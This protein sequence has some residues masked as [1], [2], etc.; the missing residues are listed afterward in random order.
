MLA[1]QDIAFQTVEMFCCDFSL[2]QGL[3]TLNSKHW[4]S[5][6]SDVLNQLLAF[7]VLDFKTNGF[8]LNFGYLLIM[9]LGHP[10]KTDFSKRTEILLR[11]RDIP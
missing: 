11:T 2:L 6:F 10:V 3:Q 9:F 8:M 7:T 1:R 4:M 5:K